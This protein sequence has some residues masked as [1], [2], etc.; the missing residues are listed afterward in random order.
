MI[1]LTEHE[2]I[3]NE[4]AYRKIGD[5]TI[6]RLIKVDRLDGSL[7]P[8]YKP[9]IGKTFV[10]DQTPQI[11]FRMEMTFFITEENNVPLRFYG[12]STRRLVDMDPD[13]LIFTTPKAIYYCETVQDSEFEMEKYYFR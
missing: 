1:E 10:F 7:P 5:K 3:L 2:K 11:G 13:R 4:E 9:I 6:Y 12:W 8:K